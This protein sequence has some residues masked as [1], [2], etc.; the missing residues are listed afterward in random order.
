VVEPQGASTILQVNVGSDLK[1]IVQVN[2]QWGR[3]AGERL[4]LSIPAE[5]IHLFDPA[6]E[7]KVS[8]Q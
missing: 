3:E 7:Q 5:S 4:R 2:E 1:A 8:N 6:T